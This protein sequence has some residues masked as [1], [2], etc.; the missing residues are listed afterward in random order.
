MTLRSFRLAATA[1]LS[2]VAGSLVTS[3]L[4]IDVRNPSVAKGERPTW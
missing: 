1:V 3:Q 2:F 4:T